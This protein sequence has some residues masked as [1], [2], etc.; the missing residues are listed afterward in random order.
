MFKTDPFLGHKKLSLN[1]NVLRDHANGVQINII[2]TKKFVKK[3]RQN[4]RWK[5]RQNFIKN[6]RQKIRQKLHHRYTYHT[7]SELNKAPEKQFERRCTT[8]TPTN[9]GF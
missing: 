2:M 3:I 7:W 6:I 1:Q 4:I 9:L 5:I 8:K